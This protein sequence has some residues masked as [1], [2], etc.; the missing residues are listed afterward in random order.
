[1]PGSLP[2]GHR[3]PS[4]R[5][6]FTVSRR[7]G[8]APSRGALSLPCALNPGSQS[9][10]PPPAPPQVSFLLCLQRPAPHAWCH[11]M[12]RT[13]TAPRYRAR[14]RRLG[15]RPRSGICLQAAPH[16]QRAGSAIGGA[17]SKGAGGPGLGFLSADT[18]HLLTSWGRA[19]LL[20]WKV[21]AR[22]RPSRLAS[23]FLLACVRRSCF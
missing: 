17:A 1:M 12:T 2:G 16:G 22:D 3:L 10:H 20:P 21:K 23:A 11:I 13:A 8:L 14:E 4:R 19:D 9:P 15:F 5:G 7:A 18:A 6:C